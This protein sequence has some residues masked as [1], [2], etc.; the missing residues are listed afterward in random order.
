M[1][2][3]EKIRR[4]DDL[5][6]GGPDAALSP[7]ML[8]DDLHTAWKYATRAVNCCENARLPDTRQ[9]VA[10]IVVKLSQQLEFIETQLQSERIIAR[11]EQRQHR[12]N[13]DQESHP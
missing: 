11:R 12:E 7:I 5:L 4:S 10:D 9:A 13:Y 8:Q 3:E 6:G 2:E 1:N